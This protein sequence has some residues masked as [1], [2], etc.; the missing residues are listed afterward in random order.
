MRLCGLRLGGRLDRY[1]AML[2]CMSYLTAFLLVVGLFLIIDMTTNLDDYLEPGKDGTSPSLLTVAHYYVLH[3][4]FLYLQ[5]SP[6]VTLVAGLFAAAKLS[7]AN[8]IVA[9]LGAGV[10]ARR[11]LVP[12][13]V[14]AA[15]LSAGMIVLREWATT[16]IGDR[17]DDV[18]DYLRERRPVPVYESVYFDDANHRTVYVKA[19]RKRTENGGPPTIDGLQ[20]DYRTQTGWVSIIVPQATW[21]A[22]PRQWCLTGAT[23]GVVDARAKHIQNIS[24]LEDLRFTPEDVE[25]AWK[26]R[27]NPLERSFSECLRLLEQDP[28]SAQFRSL[29]HYHLTFPL[30]GLVLLLVGLPFVVDQRRGRGLERIAAGFLVCVAYF[31]IDLV[32]RT[33]GM[34]GQIGPIL[35]GWLPIL[36]FG[37]LGVVLFGSM[38]S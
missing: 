1:I 37:S 12:V 14:V 8:E 10:S 13:F 23:R 27:H 30:A 35:S 34:D 25:L 36:L 4:P 18:V 32:S 11:V 28:A 16:E 26:G 24:T 21:D 33:M 3:M 17:R 7:R 2:F 15:M 6:F 22:K 38:R 29:F 9:G 19:Y 20:C 31:G 5:V